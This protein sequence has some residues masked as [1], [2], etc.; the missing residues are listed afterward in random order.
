MIKIII[1]LY[2]TL[3]YSMENSNE[4]III[5]LNDEIKKINGYFNG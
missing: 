2:R 4:N 3:D 5:N 1:S